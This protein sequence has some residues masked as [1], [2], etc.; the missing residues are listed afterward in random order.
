MS[1]ATSA[2]LFV[3]W[4]F[5]QLNSL[6]AGLFVSWSFCQLVS[7][8]AGLFVSWSFCQL[9]SSSVGLFVSWPLRQLASSS[10]GLKNFRNSKFI[11]YQFS[12]VKLCKMLTLTNVKNLNEAKLIVFTERFYFLPES[13][14]CKV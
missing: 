11:F 7:S 3:I 10:A 13:R 4:S 12:L 9:V 2:K 8:S 5:C 14:F 6:S 1:H